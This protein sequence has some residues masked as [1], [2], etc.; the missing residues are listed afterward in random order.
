MPD[1]TTILNLQYLPQRHGLTEPM[2]ADVNAHLTGKGIFFS[3]RVVRDLAQ[4][5]REAEVI[6]ANRLTDE[7]S[8]VGARV[9]TRDLFGAD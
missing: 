1:E 2:F 3:S 5:K 8:D 6:V 4:F 9:F 7:I